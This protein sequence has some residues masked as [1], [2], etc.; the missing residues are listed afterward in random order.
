MRASVLIREGNEGHSKNRRGRSRARVDAL[1][2]A[3]VLQVTDRILTAD[4]LRE[5]LASRA[6]EENRNR[7]GIP[8]T[9]H[10][11]WDKSFKQQRSACSE[12]FQLAA[13]TVVPSFR[14]TGKG[15]L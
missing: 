13:D 14:R 12:R 15:G 4:D 9:R 3:G 6:P 7:S 10:V 8:P 1:A 2:C 11:I 5:A